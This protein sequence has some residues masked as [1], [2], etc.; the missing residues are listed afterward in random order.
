MPVPIPADDRLRAAAPEAG[1]PGRA[2]GQPLDPQFAQKHPARILVA[3]DNAVNQKVIMRLLQKMGYA[4]KA[5]A[6]GAEAVRAL[7]ESPYDIVLMDVEMPEMDGPT[8]AAMVR[9]ELPADRQPAIV[10]LTAHS[11]DGRGQRF[12]DAGM[13]S[14]LAKPIRIPELTRLLALRG[15]LT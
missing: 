4:P 11:L 8:A 10:A 1:R 9:R 14:Y 15:R 2:G 6:N 7:R 5:V 13:D 12:K 3:E